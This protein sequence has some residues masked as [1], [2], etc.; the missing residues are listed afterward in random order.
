MRVYRRGQYVYS[1]ALR[2][3]GLDTGCRRSNVYVELA[4]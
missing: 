1:A 3:A 2:L 4:E